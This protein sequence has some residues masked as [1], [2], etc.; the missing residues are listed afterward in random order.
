MEFSRI[1]ASRRR[2]YIPYRNEREPIEI[3]FSGSKL[4]LDLIPHADHEGFQAD[5]IPSQ[6]NIYDT[7]K[8]RDDSHIVEWQR[9]GMACYVVGKRSWELHGN[10]LNP[11]P[12]SVDFL[13]RV[14]RID[15]LPE[16]MS[17]FNPAHFEQVL[18]R[19]TYYK[20][21]ANPG[22]AKR[23]APVNWQTQVKNEGTW[24]YYE[25]RRD[26]SDE[27]DRQLTF[28]P[29][30]MD[31]KLCIPLDD[32]YF[33]ELDFRYLGY[34]PVEPCLVNMNE[35]RDSV[36]NSVQTSLG[37]SAMKALQRAKQRWPNAEAQKKREPEP[38]IYPEIRKGLRHEGEPEFVILKAGS[39]P[40]EFKP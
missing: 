26:F 34:A 17:C 2:P 20:G 28:E 6:V 37:A 21:P 10:L 22:L 8:Y 16:G 29:T 24:I 39:P 19:S 7:N 13:I 35:L 14:F 27:P 1:F 30:H 33:V 32:R 9:E 15:S 36:C 23:K 3:D 31:S 5:D 12:G 38:W 4:S 11:P 18:L 40:P 25:S